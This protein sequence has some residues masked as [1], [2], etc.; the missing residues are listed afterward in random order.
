ML[1]RSTNT[2]SLLSCDTRLH[3][4]AKAVPVS[5]SSAAVATIHRIVFMLFPFDLSIRQ[6][7]LLHGNKC[8]LPQSKHEDRQVAYHSFQFGMTEGKHGSTDC[9]GLVRANRR[10]GQ[11]FGRGPRDEHDPADRQQT[12]D[13]AGTAAENPAAQ[14]QHPAVVA[15]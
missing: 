7:K 9:N 6:Q 12:T 13:G 4:S 8:S 2:I 3:S 5:N 1:V 15:D 14:S 10:N 11:F